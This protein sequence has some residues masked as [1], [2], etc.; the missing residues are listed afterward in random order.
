MIIIISD[1]IIGTMY[2]WWVGKEGTIP[3]WR[4][5]TKHSQDGSLTTI[6]LKGSVPTQ[7]LYQI[8]KQRNRSVKNYQNL[9]EKTRIEYEI[10]LVCQ[11]VNNLGRLL[12]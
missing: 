11:F 8:S 9:I 12:R 7:L 2:M 1:I 3:W 6:K 5:L 10:F 4:A